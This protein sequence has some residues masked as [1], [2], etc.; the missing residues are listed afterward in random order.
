MVGLPAA[1]LWILVRNR[2]TLR[3]FG[4][5]SEHT[6][7]RYGFLYASYGP[8]AW[9]WEVEELIRKLLLT[10]AVVRCDSRACLRVCLWALTAYRPKRD[11]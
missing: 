11:V 6:M 10:A 8:A 2:S 9:F 5:H 4:P 7:R 1:V 3:L